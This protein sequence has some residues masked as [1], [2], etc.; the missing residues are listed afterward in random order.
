MMRR[1]FFLLSADAKELPLGLVQ[2]EKNGRRQKQKVKKKTKK[3]NELPA[4]GKWRLTRLA[5]LVAPLES[6]HNPRNHE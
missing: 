2:A 4:G 3:K 6:Q 1:Q 5:A